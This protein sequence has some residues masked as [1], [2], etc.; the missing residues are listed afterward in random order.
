MEVSERAPSSIAARRALSVVRRRRLSAARHRSEHASRFQRS[1][2]PPQTAQTGCGEPTTAE[3]SQDLGHRHELEAGRI[4]GSLVACQVGALSRFM[5][6]DLLPVRL[7]DASARADLPAGGQAFADRG[8]GGRAGRR[9]PAVNEVADE[10]A[11]L[12]QHGVTATK[13]TVEVRRCSAPPA[14]GW[15]GARDADGV[16]PRRSP[17][18][19]RIPHPTPYN[20]AQVQRCGTSGHSCSW[21]GG[22]VAGRSRFSPHN[23]KV[24]GSNPAPAITTSIPGA[25]G[26]CGVIGRRGRVPFHGASPAYEKRTGFSDQGPSP[27]KYV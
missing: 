2:G 17:R 25:N 16:G 23:P 13:D 5:K 9:P 10:R 20:P 12:T 11:L 18:T 14:I 8:R 22:L 3:R 27:C 24:A 6:T 7:M 19:L 4:E 21:F 15:S 26:K 1:R